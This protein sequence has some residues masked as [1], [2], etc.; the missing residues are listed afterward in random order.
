MEGKLLVASKLKQF[1]P[2]DPSFLSPK[3]PGFLFFYPSL[4]PSG[5]G[6]FHHQC[7]GLH[8]VCG[9]LLRRW[10]EEKLQ[11]ISQMANGGFFHGDLQWFNIHTKIAKKA[12]NSFG[13]FQEFTPNRAF[14]CAS[15]CS[16]RSSWVK[17]G[18][19]KSS[20]LGNTPH[21]GSMG[22]RENSWPFQSIYPHQRQGN[23]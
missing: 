22:R 20:N 18:R 19:E 12:N 11:K 23:A 15:R 10:L 9:I 4:W 2:K 1:H 16:S 13:F 7:Y 5:M 14:R 8:W 21:N 17:S 3:N 6:F